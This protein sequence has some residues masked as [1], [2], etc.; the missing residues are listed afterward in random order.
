MKAKTMTQYPTPWIYDE[1]V[2]GIF[3]ANDNQVADISCSKEVAEFIINL[4]NG[5]E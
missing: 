1:G 4:V 3:D 5:V 2:H